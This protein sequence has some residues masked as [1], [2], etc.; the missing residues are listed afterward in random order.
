MNEQARGNRDGHLTIDASIR[1]LLSHTAFAGFGRLILPWDDRAYDGNMRL[2]NIGALLPYHSHVNPGDVV[3]ALNRMIDDASSGKTVFYD[4]YTGAQKQQSRHERIPGCSSS[5][6]GPAHP[7]PSSPPAAASPMSAPST[8]AFP[9]PRR[10][11][12]KDTMRSC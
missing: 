1:D 2:S 8:K 5:G 6:E 10:S 3:T 9:T 11:A 7:S 4:F 12:R